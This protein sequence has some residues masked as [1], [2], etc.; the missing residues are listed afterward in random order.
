MALAR[1]IVN[2]RAIPR[3]R[4]VGRVL[5]PATVH[6]GRVLQP[7]TGA[8][9]LENGGFENPPYIS[10]IIPARNE[11][12][13]IETTVRALLAQ[14]YPHFEVIVV[15]DRS[16]DA[17]PAI[18]ASID[19]PRLIVIHGA[20]AP[21]GWLG[22]P[23]ALQQGAARAKGEWLLF[24]D[25]DVRYAPGGV[26]AAVAH[27]QKRDV[28]LLSLLPRFEL[29]G[30]WEHAA[31]PQLA[32]TVFSFIP[33]WLGEWKQIPFL[34][35]GGGPGNL[36]RRAD[37]DA[38]GGHESMRDA[39]VDDVSLA[40]RIRR[41]GKRTE[42]V[43][44]DDFVFLHMYHGAREI[45]DGFTKNAFAVFGRNYALALITTFLML[46]VHLFPYP[47]ALLGYPMAIATVVV[48]SVTRVILFRSLGYP[49]WSAIL[50]HPVM[51]AI[52]AWIFLRSTW[53]TGVRRQLHW[54]GRTYDAAETKFGHER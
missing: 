17:T 35:I 39:V 53:L 16:T 22:K 6:V 21:A 44:A 26:S 2:L 29:D 31:M 47:L 40:R 7:A 49:L 25:A 18:L 37:Y 1:T 52:W 27:M 28:S 13:V 3:L 51:I 50:L 24:I 36:V 34:A 9:G 32:M 19:D 5:Q 23:W 12:Q 48:I 41:S 20:D 11:E 43:R 54:R 42:T 38:I 33:T 14:D 15:D 10:V 45:I 30:F 4:H 46:V 8:G